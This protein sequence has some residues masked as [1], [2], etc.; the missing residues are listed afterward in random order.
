MMHTNSPRSMMRSTSR[1]AATGS[2]RWS[3]TLLTCSSSIQGS[4]SWWGNRTSTF[5]PQLA[6]GVFAE[7]GVGAVDAALPR[8]QPVHHFD[9]L[10]VHGAVAHIPPLGLAAV[11]GDNVDKG[12]VAGGKE[13]PPVQGRPVVPHA[14]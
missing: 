9:H 7:R 6:V 2:L 3:Y 14:Q 8:H 11:G 1:S 4:S 10:A 5:W 12:R 13:G